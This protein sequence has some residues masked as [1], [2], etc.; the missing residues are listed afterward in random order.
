MIKYFGLAFQ[1]S[2]DFDDI[3]QDNKRVKTSYNPNIVCK[4]GITEAH[5][6][7]KDA[8]TQ[9]TNLSNE[10]NLNHL[11]FSELCDFLNNRVNVIIKILNEKNEKYHNNRQTIMIY[12]FRFSIS[13]I[14]SPK[15]G[16][17]LIIFLSF[18]VIMFIINSAI[19]IYNIALNNPIIINNK[20]FIYYN[21]ILFNFN[22]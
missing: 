15:I 10:L 20:T 7:Y 16:I 1:I 21:I 19:H 2:D 17:F 18:C 8:L 11:I 14:C 5:N 6:I 22:F 4:Y 13:A 12:K 3:E 9:F